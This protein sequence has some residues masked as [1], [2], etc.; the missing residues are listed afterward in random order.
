MKLILKVSA[1]ALLSSVA[2]AQQPQG[3]AGSSPFDVLDADKNAAISVAEA[4]AVPVVAENFTA[5]DKNGDGALTREEFNSAFTMAK[6]AEPQS[7]Q[8]P[9]SH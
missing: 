4:R 6:P 7:S 8:Q 5:A 1:A 2:F 9:Q 3:G